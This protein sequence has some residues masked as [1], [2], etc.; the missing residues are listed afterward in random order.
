MCIILILASTED[1]NEKRRLEFN[2]DMKAKYWCEK[3]RSSDGDGKSQ[4]QTSSFLL[5]LICGASNVLLNGSVALK[6]FSTK[7]YHCRL[8]A[9]S[10]VKR[11]LGLRDSKI[12]ARFGYGGFWTMLGFLLRSLNSSSW[13]FWTLKVLRILNE[14]CGEISRKGTTGA[15]RKEIITRRSG[16][17]RT[18]G[19]YSNLK[20]FTNTNFF[21]VLKSR[22]NSPHC[23]QAEGWREPE[24]IVLSSSP[25]SSTQACTSQTGCTWHIT[26]RRLHLFSYLSY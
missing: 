4:T 20:C 11:D 26:N 19:K 8:F 2:E 12:Y 9:A 3:M 15:S 14:F 23:L 17:C 5:K 6:I 22:L 18:P 13:R 10:N 16:L 1:L 21:Q 7:S 24:S 25:K